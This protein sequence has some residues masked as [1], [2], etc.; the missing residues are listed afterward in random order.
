MRPHGHAHRAA[1]RSSS[2]PAPPSA[3]TTLAWLRGHAPPDG[4]VPITDAPSSRVCFGLWGPRPATSW[5]PPRTDDVS[6]AAFPYLTARQITVGPVPLLAVRVTYVGELGWELYAPS[7]YGMAARGRPLAA[8]RPHGHHR[9]RLP[10]YR[11]PP[12]REGLSRLG[13]ATSRPRRRRT[14]RDW[15]S[16]SE[17]TRV[18]FWGGMCLVAAEA[19][20]PRE[21][22]PDAWCSTTPLWVCLGNEPVSLGGEVVG[23]VTSGGY[24]FS[25]GSEHRVCV[26]APRHGHRLGVARWNCSARRWASRWCGRPCST[27]PA[28][29]PGPRRGMIAA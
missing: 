21:A 29:E 17:S 19:A 22:A 26:P 2:S 27:R 10:G 6:N 13:R 20:R 16:P 24:G 28:R 14:R 5:A 18:D 4:S 15:A 9:R 3:T 25:V 23:R 1:T 12:T 11:L 8:G 7:E